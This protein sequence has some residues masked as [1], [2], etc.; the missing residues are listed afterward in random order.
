MWASNHNCK[1][2]DSN[3]FID[4][5]VTSLSNCCRLKSD[6]SDLGYFNSIGGTALSVGSI[7]VNT[8]NLANIAYAS[9]LEAYDEFQNRSIDNCDIVFLRFENTYL[10]KLKDQVTLNIKVLDVIRKIIIKNAKDRFS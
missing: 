1:W 3:F 10:Q 5:T 6:I 4:D 7:K 9:V 2:L 8:V